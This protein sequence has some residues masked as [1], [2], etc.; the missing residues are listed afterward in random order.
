MLFPDDNPAPNQY[1]VKHSSLS[2]L[3][4]PP[5]CKLGKRLTSATADHTTGPGPAAYNTRP[6]LNKQGGTIT[7][8][9][10]SHKGIQYME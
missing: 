5:S 10:Q 1:D 2:S 3:K 4:R 8:R 6:N 7:P 9:R